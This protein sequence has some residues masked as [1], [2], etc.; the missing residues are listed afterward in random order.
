MALSMLQSR[1]NSKS[2]LS[3]QNLQRMWRI[4]IIENMDAVCHSD[5]E[6]AVNVVR[7]FVPDLR[8]ALLSLIRNTECY[9]CY[10]LCAEAFDILISYIVPCDLWSFSFALDY[11]I[12]HL[13][14]KLSKDAEL[15]IPEDYVRFIRLLSLVTGSHGRAIGQLYIDRNIQLRL[16]VGTNDSDV[17]STNSYSDSD[18][19]EL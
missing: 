17:A 19:L 3:P 14:V 5:P 10:S 13:S 18:S 7:R 4:H 2:T 8:N 9:F 15:Y 11:V 16:L 12:N 6:H 1:N